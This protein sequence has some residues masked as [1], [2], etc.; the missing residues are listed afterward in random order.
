MHCGNMWKAD[1]LTQWHGEG[2]LADACRRQGLSG[3]SD[4]RQC[5]GNKLMHGVL[6]ESWGG[7]TR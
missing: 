7:K 5:G 4:A 2:G 3:Q 6:R 1:K